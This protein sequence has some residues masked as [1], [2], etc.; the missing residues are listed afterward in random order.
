MKQGN[1]QAR[2]KTRQRP[3]SPVDEHV[4]VLAREEER[5]ETSWDEDPAIPVAEEKNGPGDQ[6]LGL[7]L[8]QMGAIPLLE[9]DEEV[10]LTRRLDHLRRRYR[11]AVLWS[12][13]VLALAVETF[14]RVQSGQLNLERN[15]DVLPGAGLTAAR[16][17]ERLPEHLPRL[18]E[19]VAQARLD[20]GL[21]RRQFR[22]AVRLAEE[23]SPRT[24]L[25]D[26]WTAQFQQ[27]GREER[28]G[29]L[30]II[31]RR[32]VQYQ[33]ARHRLAEAN[34]RLVVSVAKRY[35]G[36]GLPFADLIQEGNS[37]LMRAVDKFD[38]RL[39][40]RFGTYATWWI[41]QGMTRGLADQARMVRVPSHHHST[42]AAI[43]RVRSELA[44]RMEREPQAADVAHVLG[45]TTEEVQALRVAGRQPSSLD[46]L[47]GGDDP[48]V[49]LLSDNSPDP[50]E[51]ADERL[52]QERIAQMLR[53]LPPRD[54]EV[55]EL[56][57]GLREGR[58][59]TLGEV[60]QQLGVTRERVRQIEARGLRKLQQQES[61]A[62]AL[63]A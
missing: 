47:C 62:N 13:D 41:R 51:V 50:A 63:V 57:F 9:R 34:L 38:P 18:R 59:H 30:G 17:R 43:E 8:E 48:F 27:A 39:G 24:E 19:L 10:E 42:L 1:Q 2:R 11:R 7:Y 33:Q 25:L 3:F 5:A 53:C 15:V 52:L 44:T 12:P 6:G 36:R 4:D 28:T 23:L 60:A 16:I 55:I 35:R 22:E 21:S 26:A 37:G 40:F 49:A 46:D 20:A 56:R 58:P 45:L 54:R 14:E 61:K 31:R 29:L 32:R